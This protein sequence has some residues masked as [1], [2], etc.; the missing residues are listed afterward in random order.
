MA[1]TQ[2][3]PPV[4]AAFDAFLVPP[5]FLPWAEELVRRADPQPGERVLDVACGSGAVTLLLRP[6]VG[7]AGSVVGLDVSADML[8]L[9]R[10]KAAAAGLDVEWHEASALELP[11]GAGSFGLV[12]C[13]QGLQFFPDRGRGAAEMRRMLVLGGRAAVACWRALDAQP[14]F[15]A[16]FPAVER[17]LGVPLVNRPTYSLGRAGELRALLEGAGFR[18]VEVEAVSKTVRFPDPGRWAATWLGVSQ[19]AQDA[20]ARLDRAERE[21]LVARVSADVGPV[22]REHTDGGMLAMPT[23]TYIAMAST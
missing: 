8:G 23:H 4:A 17:H 18:R 15:R 7:A 10:A 14:I 5:M 19:D 21:R 2:H 13:Q 9:A 22:I 16:L 3:A 12:L 11:F 20:L 1:E 6:L